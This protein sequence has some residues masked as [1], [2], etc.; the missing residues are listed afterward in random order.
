MTC[1]VAAADGKKVV[2]GGDSLG[3]HSRGSDG[4]PRADAK[5]FRSGPYV[6]GFTTS[7]RMGQILRYLTTFPD[8]PDDS[9][10][11]VLE[12]FFV[13][14]LVPAIKESFREHGFD[15]KASFPSAGKEDFQ[16]QGVHVGGLFIVGVNGRLFEIREDFQVSRPA[17]PYSAIGTGAPVAHG[18]LHALA[19]ATDLKLEERVKIALSAS[20]TYCTVVRAPF[21]FVSTAGPA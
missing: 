18:A 10:P 14:E 13:A 9:D 17:A 16:I 1:I 20:Q 19:T 7:Y 21:H 5:V 2:L 12:R 11:E 3:S 8:P 4:I 15:L 6:I